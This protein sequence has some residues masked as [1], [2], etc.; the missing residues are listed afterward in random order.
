MKG[1]KFLQYNRRQLSRI[2]PKG[3]RLD[4]S[5]YDPMPM[6]LCGSQLV[7]LN[8]QT[9]D[10]PMQMNQTLFQSGGRCGYVLQPGSMRDDAF[11]P[12]DKCSLRMLEPVI[13][14]IEVLGARHLPKNGRGI[15]CPFVEVEV[16]GAEYDNAKQKTDIVVDNGLNPVWPQ[17]CFH[18]LITNPEFAFLRFVVYEED[19]FSDQNFL[20][21]AS[22]VVRGLKTGFRAVPLKNNYIEDL[23][24]ASLLVKIDIYPSKENGEVNGAS[25]PRERMNDQSAGRTRD[26]PA[27]SRYSSNQLE[28]FRVSQEQLSEH[29]DRERR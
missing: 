23:E 14:C 12:F 15:V 5:N 8:F 29:F 13:V 11:D 20:A 1:K 6:W 19:M 17:K 24:L 22:F 3:Q 26:S 21:Q 28:D 7:A 4:S 10:K 25:A 27:E 18:F 16:C 9:P 2:Y